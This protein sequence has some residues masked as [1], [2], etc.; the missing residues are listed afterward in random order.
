MSPLK[1]FIK[2]GDY[3]GYKYFIPEG[4]LLKQ[5]NSDCYKYLISVVILLVMLTNK[6]TP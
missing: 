3:P 5:R 2:T 1:W 6:K 4:I